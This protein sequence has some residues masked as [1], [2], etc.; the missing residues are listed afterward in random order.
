M[1]IVII[2]TISIS[3]TLFGLWAREIVRE[4][5]RFAGECHRIQAI[6][7]AE[8]GVQRAIALKTAD[9]QF[10]QQVWTVPAESLG[11]RQVAIVQ[12]EVQPGKAPGSTTYTAIA[13]Y[14]ADARIRA[15][16]TRR[17]EVTSP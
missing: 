12:I 8:A 11:G 1:L 7:L 6:A 9:P 10:Q 15:Q 13:K 17:I 5:R 4:H 3:L 2:V 14:P 16:I